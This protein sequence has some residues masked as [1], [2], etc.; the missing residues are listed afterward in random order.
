MKK[1][2]SYCLY[3]ERPKDVVNGVVNCFLAKEIYPDWI[4]RFYIDDTIPNSIKRILETFDNV[5]IVEMPRHQSSEAMLWRF[6]PASEE[7]VDIM[8]SR[9]ADSWLSYRELSCV[10]DFLNSDKGFHIIRDHCYHSQK[11]MG[12]MWGIKK[13]IFPDMKNLVEEYIKNNTYDQGFLADFVYPHIVENSLIHIGDQYDNSG[14]KTEGYF[15]DGAI[16]I[17]HY[18][19]LNIDNFS[20]AEVNRINGFHCLHCNKTHDTFIG[21][22]MTNIPQNTKLFLMNYFSS[23]GVDTSILNNI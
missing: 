5:E 22:I 21:G 18:Q 7:D 2:I 1:I 9:D 15:N 10:N 12:G 6:L 8:I 3:N 13:G 20:F 4:C 11:I 19:D 17:P 14:R 23:F 16:P